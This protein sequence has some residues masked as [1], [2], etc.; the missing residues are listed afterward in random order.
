[1]HFRFS[2]VFGAEKQCE[3]TDALAT[4]R[5]ENLATGRITVAHFDLGAITA[6]DEAGVQLLDQAFAELSRV[7]V[8]LRVEPPAANTP[9]RAFIQAAIDGRFAWAARSDPNPAG[10]DQG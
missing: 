7:G 4:L 9:S 8:T 6:L 1:V 3:V 10:P 5:R 2:G